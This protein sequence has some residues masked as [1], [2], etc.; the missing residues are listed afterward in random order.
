MIGEALEI[1]I[2]VSMLVLV[3]YP[4]SVMVMETLQ[5]RRKRVRVVQGQY[6]RVQRLPLAGTTRPWEKLG[7]SIHAHT[8]DS[9][10]AFRRFQRS[11]VLSKSKKDSVSSES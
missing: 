10:I 7:R 1:T 9:L 5:E 3:G 6:R 4:S 2:I 8:Q 11:C